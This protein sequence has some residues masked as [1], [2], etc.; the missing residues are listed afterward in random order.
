MVEYLLFLAV[1]QVLKILWHFEILIWESIGKTKML[2]NLKTGDR[3]AKKMKI[4]DS[5][6]YSAYI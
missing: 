1:G 2:N 3:S 6:Y 5:G 4:L